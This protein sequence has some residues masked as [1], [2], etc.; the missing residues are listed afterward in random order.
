[1]KI[2]IS[3]LLTLLLC[4]PLFAASETKQPQTIV[5][6]EKES[7]IKPFLYGTLFGITAVSATWIFRCKLRS[8]L[9]WNQ[10]TETLRKEINARLAAIEAN[11]TLQNADLQTL[12]RDTQSIKADTHFVAQVIQAHLE[13]NKPLMQKA[14]DQFK[15]TIQKLLGS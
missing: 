13:G 12:K 11:Q 7:S 8:R 10:A 6:H 4:A 15:K 2:K 1:M 9:P 5:I 3:A 14:L